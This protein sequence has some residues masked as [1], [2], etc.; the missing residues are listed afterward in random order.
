MSA[1]LIGYARC[2]TDAQNL[3]A[4]PTLCPLTS[5][6]SH[7]RPIFGEYFGNP[8]VSCTDDHAHQCRLTL[9]IEDTL[10]GMSGCRARSAACAE[11]AV[12]R[13]ILMRRERDADR[14]SS[15]VAKE[16]G[17]AH[18][19]SKNAQVKDLGILGGADGIRTRDPRTA[20]AVRYQLRY[21]PEEITTVPP[22][23]VGHRTRGRG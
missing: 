8:L 17:L 13:F 3:M 21:S 5:R 11:C 6:I 23:R 22:R 14:D 2:S 4:R 7:I 20:S 18:R 12:K 10:L 9:G 16:E 19:T 1:T 15:V